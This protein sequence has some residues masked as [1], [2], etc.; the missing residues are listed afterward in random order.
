[1]TTSEGLIFGVMVFIAI[2]LLA[3]AMIVPTAGTAAQAN[4]KMR[5]RM[6]QHLQLQDPGTATLI[7][8]QYLGKLSPVERGIE[9]LPFL[10]SLSQLVEQS[11]ESTS[12]A[13]TLT[14]SLLFALVVAVPV[15]VYS[16]SVL[17]SVL[18]GLAAAFVPLILLLRK[19][20]QRIVI[21]EEQLADSLGVMARALKAGH[22]LTETFNLIA[23]EM[24]DPIASEFGRVFS[25]LNYGMPL[26]AA[27]QSMLVRIPSV[28]LHSF[29]T[30]VLIQNESGGGLAEILENVAEVIRS[31]FKLQRKIKTV[32]AEGRMSAWVLAMVPFA[33]AGMLMISTPDYLPVLFTDPLGQK[34]ILAA[35]VMLCLGI[36]WIRRIIRI[37]V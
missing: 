12:V 25:D 28:S 13:K 33:L 21:F 14:K 19:R 16:R 32:S 11:G 5:Q 10:Q 37:E 6:R 15:F 7:R 26:K 1:M 23:E 24:Q 18:A 8:E 31:R 30:A 2:V 17:F 29:V 9:K 22:P 20:A 36:F 3:T 35:F 27:L 4:R 34:I